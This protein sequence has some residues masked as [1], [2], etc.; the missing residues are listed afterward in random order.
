MSGID[1]DLKKWNYGYRAAVSMINTLELH[2][3]GCGK[4]ITNAG[5]FLEYHGFK[6]CS[7]PCLDKI[8]SLP[9][10]ENVFDLTPIDGATIQ[11]MLRRGLKR[12]GYQVTK[13]Q[14]LNVAH[15]Q[16]KANILFSIELVEGAEDLT[17]FKVDDRTYAIGKA[18]T[19]LRQSKPLEIK[20]VKSRL[21]T[22]GD[23]IFRL[24]PANRYTVGETTLRVEEILKGYEGEPVRKIN[25]TELAGV[26]GVSKQ[27]VHQIFKKLIA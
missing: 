18:I 21:T 4:L 22:Y 17:S 19:P 14:V 6:A 12:K 23:T 1:K 20:K 15:Y 8:K 3:Q 24:K 27:R 7:N 26:I 5:G 25:F 13:V 9:L 16:M 10:W 2:C 11:G